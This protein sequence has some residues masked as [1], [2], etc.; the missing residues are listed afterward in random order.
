MSF[1]SIGQ[2][3]V[4]V[5]NKDLF[6]VKFFCDTSFL[7]KFRSLLMRAKNIGTVVYN[8]EDTSKHAKILAYNLVYISK[9]ANFQ[10]FFLEKG[11][12]ITGNLR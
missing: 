10:L 1:Q 5:K 8:L 9:N 2:G 12:L 11:V 7:G 3:T 4:N 6:S